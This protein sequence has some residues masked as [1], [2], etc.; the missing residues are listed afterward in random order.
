MKSKLIPTVLMLGVVC[1]TNSCSKSTEA[2]VPTSIVVSPKPLIITSLNHGV[3]LTAAVLDQHGDTVKPSPGFLWSSDNLAVLA[4]TPS[5]LAS[6]ASNGTANVTVTAPAAGGLTKGTLATVAQAASA[7]SKSGGDAQT[8]LVST[9]LAQPLI[10]HV[11][12]AGGTPVPGATVNFA[13]TTGGGSVGTS[14]A[15]SDAS[16]NASTTWTLGSVAGSQSMTAT[17]G[18]APAAQ[19]SASAFNAGTPASIIGV[20]GLGQPA[21]VGYATNVRPAVRVL[22]GIGQPVQGVTVTFAVTAGGGSVTSASVVTNSAGNA[23]VG[24]W[25]VGA[26]PGTNT[27]SASIPVIGVN[28]NP[29]AFTANGAAP[30]FNITLQNFGSTPPPEALAAFDSA[31]AKWQRIIY[32]DL[33]NINLPA[34]TAG[35]CGGSTP[36]IPAQTIDDVLILWSVDSIDGVGKILG[37]AGPC[38]IRTAGGLTIVGV[39]QFDS[40]DIRGLINT[41]NLN[42]V[43]LHEMGHVLGFGSLWSLSNFN[44]LQNAVPNMTSTDTYF[45]CGSARSAFDSIGGT[46][47]TGGNKVPVENCVGISNCGAGTYNSH[48]RELVFDNEL[49]TGFLN[50]GVPNPLSRMTIASMEDLGY[51]VNYAAADPYS[52]TFSSAAAL[53]AAELPPLDLGD[54]LYHGPLFSVDRAGNVRVV[55]P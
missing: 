11:V 19:F 52:K 35:T 13:V 12:D 33:A 9:A 15:S 25:T 6:A 55:R 29:V 14:S 32:G 47:Y 53:R 51:T 3:Q 41:G 42:S 2:L 7:V 24:S 28:G 39:M 16:G 8:G 50:N 38:F 20:A 43:I 36:A 10:V 44:C 54:H 22:D 34:Q 17:S 23:Q 21:L 26:A 45:S 49:M 18:A 27:L 4:I 46:N 1:A 30:A 5:G 40:A 37:Q 48:W 31:V